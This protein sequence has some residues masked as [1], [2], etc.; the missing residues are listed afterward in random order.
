VQINQRSVLIMDN[1][2]PQSQLEPQH[3]SY[4]Q[5]FIHWIILAFLVIL[6]SVIWAQSIDNFSIYYEYDTPPGQV[7]YIFSKL[8]GLYAV[9]LLWLQ[10]LLGLMRHTSYW[11]GRNISI[12][13]HRNLGIT[14][15]S[16]LILHAALFVTAVSIRKNTFVYDLLLPVFDHGFYRIAVTLGILALYGLI[17]VVIAG[18]LRKQGNKKA[19]WVHRISLIAL[20]LTLIHCLLIGTETRYLT[21]IAVYVFMASSIIFMLIHRFKNRVIPLQKQ[22]S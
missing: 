17:I 10:V 5:Q 16:A 2:T 19:V 15:F 7:V 12:K 14:A 8:A 18:F 3:Q 20:T 21:M 4:Y 11:P 22:S 9:F 6:P 1:T 13:F